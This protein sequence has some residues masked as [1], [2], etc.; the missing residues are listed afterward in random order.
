MKSA[1]AALLVNRKL[2][3]PDPLAPTLVTDVVP[4]DK[5]QEEEGWVNAKKHSCVIR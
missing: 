4:D 2:L 1:F 5:H 3:G